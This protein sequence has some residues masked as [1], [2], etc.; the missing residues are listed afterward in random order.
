[1]SEQTQE[2]I[3]QWLTTRFMEHHIQTLN[4]AGYDSIEKINNTI[5]ENQQS[6]IIELFQKRGEKLKM[7][8][9]LEDLSKVRVV[10]SNIIATNT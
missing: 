6:Q 4:N 9:L 3:K 8:V 10:S 7:R 5:A 2:Q 1:M